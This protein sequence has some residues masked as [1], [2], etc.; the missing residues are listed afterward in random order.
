[1]RAGG[2][3]E[4]GARKAAATDDEAGSDAKRRRTSEEQL[5]NGAV[6]TTPMTGGI[7]SRVASPGDG[8]GPPRSEAAGPDHSADAADDRDDASSEASVAAGIQAAMAAM[9]GSDFG[10]DSGSDSSSDS[11]EAEA[12]GKAISA[13]ASAEPIPGSIAAAVAAAVAD[14]DSEE[15]SGGS[16]SSSSSESS[17][18]EDQDQDQDND[19]IAQLAIISSRIE[20]EKLARQRELET[21]C[22]AH[23]K[24]DE[25]VRI[26][27]SLPEEEAERA[28]LQALVRLTV[29]ASGNLRPEEACILAEVA[30]LEQSEPYAVTR[31]NGDHCT[32]RM[33]LRCRRGTSTRLFKISH[34]SNQE[35]TPELLD[36][37]RKLTNRAGLDADRVLARWSDKAADLHRA[38]TFEFKEDVVALMLKKKGAVEFDA[39]KESRLRSLMQ[40]AVTQMDISG[41]RGNEALELERRYVDAVQEVNALEH[42]SVKTQQEWFDKRPDLYSLK[43]INNKNLMRQMARD[44][45]ALAFTYQTERLAAE[46]G[47]NVPSNPFQ[48]R[49]CRPVCAWD[50]KLT[51]VEGLGRRGAEAAAEAESE[52]T[53]TAT[54]VEPVQQSKTLL[55]GILT[56]NGSEAQKAQAPVSR[57]DSVLRAHRRLNLLAKLGVA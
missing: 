17:D 35:L 51:A 14:S 38:K 52:A 48:R 12:P 43:E 39:Q 22:A 40:G 55:N 20:T 15:S 23:L 5:A 8:I 18:D 34:V 33:Q 50:T 2:L 46:E 32:M 54:P 45:H 44:K 31:Q 28:V 4:D 11:D 30:G 36:Q 53:P 49:S 3:P 7:A 1:M 9:P 41:I 42:K 16:S 57:V 37:W 25:L 21:A 24:R 56:A 19:P 29:Q 26:L 47:A 10:S 27:L 6:G 13:E